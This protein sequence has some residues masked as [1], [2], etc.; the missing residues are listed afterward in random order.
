MTSSIALDE[1]DVSHPALYRD[2]GWRDVFA[3]LRREAPVNYCAD[4]RYGP[5]W[6]LSCYNDIM[7]VELDH[8][9]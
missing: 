5:Y 8:G 4:S 1:I 6:S 3:R 7:G 2:D 9:T